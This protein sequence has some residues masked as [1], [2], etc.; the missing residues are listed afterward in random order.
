MCF[1]LFTGLEANG[2]ARCDVEALA[3]RQ[4]AVELQVRCQIL[5]LPI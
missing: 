2:R 3:E 1:I 4:R 5:P